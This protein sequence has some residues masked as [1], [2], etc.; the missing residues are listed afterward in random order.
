[1]RRNGILVGEDDADSIRAQLLID[2]AS[3]GRLSTGRGSLGR[4]RKVEGGMKGIMDNLYTLTQNR[5]YV[6][7]FISFSFGLSLFNAI[8][9]VLSQIL[10]PCGY[11]DDDAGNFAA[12]LIGAGLLGAGFA[13]W[14]MDTY[15]NYRFLLKAGFFCASSTTVLLS[16]SIK[17]TTTAGLYASFG[18]LGFFMIP[19]LPTM[20]ENAIEVR[21]KRD[22]KWNPSFVPRSH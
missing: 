8:L 20:I 5:Q 13:G 7:L 10:H 19:M 3:E 16:F 22:P 6:I 2:T 4:E 1:M 9:T 12:T 15:H 18:L 14:S 17:S 21:N 11:T